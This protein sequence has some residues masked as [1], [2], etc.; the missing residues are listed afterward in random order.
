MISK[1]INYHNQLLGSIYK[2]NNKI[3]KQYKKRRNSYNKLKFSN[4]TNNIN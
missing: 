1:K 2:Q 3:I 4:S